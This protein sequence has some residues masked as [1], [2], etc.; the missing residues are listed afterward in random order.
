MRVLL[1]SDGRPGHFRQSEGFVKLLEEVRPVELATLQVIRRLKIFSGLAK[2]L[3]SR[4]NLGFTTLRILY[5]M[6]YINLLPNPDLIVSC[7]RD[8]LPVG[9]ALAKFYG[10]RYTFIGN[11]RPL[12]LAS[13]VEL[14]VIAEISEEFGE[15]NGILNTKLSLAALAVPQSIK[16]AASKTTLVCIGGDSGSYKYTDSDWENLIRVI[17]TFRDASDSKIV[18]TSSRRTPESVEKMLRDTLSSADSD[19]RLVLFHEGDTTALSDLLAQA[20]RV[21]CT[22]DSNAMVQ[23]SVSTGCPVMGLVPSIDSADD[24]EQRTHDYFINNG[25]LCIHKLGV[26]RLETDLSQNF[27]AGGFSKA[28]IRRAAVNFLDEYYH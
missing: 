24:A 18:V 12:Q 6:Q 21:V 8:T 9:I 2:W 28:S 11:V 25:F 4:F 1:L 27:P 15:I 20:D 17:S 5:S 23:E 13:K 10:C 19:V 7:G 14:S 22:I 16:S 3:V 26:D